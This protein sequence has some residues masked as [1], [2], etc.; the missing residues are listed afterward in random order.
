M[1]NILKKLGYIV[2]IF[3]LFFAISAS[4]SILT[5]PQG[6]T[7]VNNISGIIQG[8][9][10]DAFS[11]ITIGSG[12]NF[13][14][15]TLSAT[16][17]IG[18]TINAGEI[19]YGS[20]SNTLTSDATKTI[21]L[22]TGFFQLSSIFT[23]PN[24]N[25]GIAQFEDVDVKGTFIR[26]QNTS[27]DHQAIVGA[28]YN[29]SLSSEVSAIMGY[30][31]VPDNLLGLVTI[32]SEGTRM[33]S[34]GPGTGAIFFTDYNGIATVGASDRF[35]VVDNMGTNQTIQATPIIG[36][37]SAGDLDGG[38]NH[39]AWY[40]DQSSSTYNI[41]GNK[42]VRPPHVD[43]FVFTGS[44]LDDLQTNAAGYSGTGATYTITVEGV[45]FTTFAMGGTTG[46]FMSGDSITDT[47]SG[48]TA[49]FVSVTNISGTN[50]LTLRSVSGS[51]STFDTVTSS[52]G[53]STTVSG[54]VRINDVATWTDGSTTVTGFPMQFTLTMSDNMVVSWSAY[55]GH[56]INN[57][58]SFDAVPQSISYQQMLSLDG[59]SHIWA[60]G[61]VDNILKGDSMLI[62][63]SSGTVFNIG[64][65]NRFVVQ[66]ND[67]SNK[68]INATYGSGNPSISIG[69]EGYGNNTFL[70]INDSS[71]QLGL[72]S[73]GE[74][75]IGD[76]NALNNATQI[77]IVDND[78][79]GGSIITLV[80]KNTITMTNV[81]GDQIFSA[82]L[83]SWVVSLG[84]TSGQINGTKINIDD[85]TGTILLG[86][87]IRYK[88][89]G[90]VA[91][92]SYTVGLGDSTIEMY[93]LTVD[94][95]LTLPP[96]PQQGDTYIIKNKEFG[97]FSVIVDG[98]GNTID[99]QTS[100]IISGS[101][102][103][104]DSKQYTYNGTEWSIY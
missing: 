59:Q 14:S 21:D 26:M 60:F 25:G 33:F 27:L 69:A 17:T 16:G 41:V 52:S 66:D 100:D 67:T 94:V 43:N 4:A 65:G 64:T 50:Y 79:L 68:L 56:T 49:T 18:G 63:D 30:S 34:Q 36:N 45:N 1:K 2:A 89:M 10:T 37:V 92:S 39:L 29:N 23:D 40:L 102:I 11:P 7:G 87:T 81:A 38:F 80:S 22:T 82:D 42:A 99:G 75:F 51:F 71:K 83:S 98:N 78:G 70:N 95:T 90:R 58:W 76:Y 77:Q 32:N 101:M 6:G 84:D 85:P 28:S 46:T 8:N 3:S 57:E 12:L 20:A 91:D 53:G 44:G 13:S 48:A 96:S 73:I 74:I 9:G 88:V 62:T 24:V 86:G 55:V 103:S 72:Q 104:E 97:T 5:V 61:D 15:G 31:D 54:V 47:T 19:G 35:L 93:P